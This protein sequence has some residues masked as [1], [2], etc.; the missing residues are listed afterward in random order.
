MVEL[1]D[2]LRAAV[3]DAEIHTDS[4]GWGQA[5]RLYALATAEEVVLEGE[6]E[7]AALDAGT[8]IPIEQEPLPDRQLYDFLAGIAWPEHVRG[9][10][11]VT[12]LLV[13]PAA[14][15]GSDDEDLHDPADADGREVRLAVGVLR[16]GEQAAC[17][18]LREDDTVVVNPVIDDLADDLVDDLA[19]ALLVTFM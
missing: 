19:G 7:L 15:D 8:L 2:N 3:I 5:T 18:R 9:C 12:E 6:P 4:A 10:V 1:T 11:L 14:D 13:L 17:A 16:S